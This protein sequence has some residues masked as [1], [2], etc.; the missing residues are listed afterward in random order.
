MALRYTSISTTNINYP[1]TDLLLDIKSHCDEEDVLVI[2]YW[3]YDSF[4]IETIGTDSSRYIVNQISKLLSGL[5]IKS[6]IIY[7]SDAIRRINH[8]EDVSRVLTSAKFNIKFNKILEIYKKNKYMDLSRATLGKVNFLATDYIICLF[9][10]ELYPEL[11]KGKL[12]KYYHNTDRFLGIK[13]E[14]DEIVSKVS[15]PVEF[16]QVIYWKSAPILKYSSREWISIK[17]SKR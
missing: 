17:M 11:A 3:D 9:F 1:I 4:D 16:P 10:N 8:N 7:M 13:K 2:C 6:N 15:S 5:N 14:V 12:I